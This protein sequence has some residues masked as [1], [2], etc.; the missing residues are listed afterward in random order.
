[1]NNLLRT[2]A[3]LASHA[4][5]RDRRRALANVDTLVLATLVTVIVSI[6]VH[7]FS[8]AP[9][10]RRYRKWAAQLPPAARERGAVADVP[11]RPTA[12]QAITPPV[13]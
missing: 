9:L 10:A 3:R 5:A 12:Q 11:A 6:V 2:K 13:K 7:G 4:R 8:A 1:M